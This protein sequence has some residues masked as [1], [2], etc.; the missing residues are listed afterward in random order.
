MLKEDNGYHNASAL[1]VARSDRKRDSLRALLKAIPQLRIIG[2]VDDASSALKLIADHQPA[3]TLLDFNLPDNEAW[4]V[5]KQIKTE[6][7]QCRCL[8]LIDTIQQRRMAEAAHAD[9]ML[10]NGFSIDEFFAISDRL[11]SR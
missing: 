3:L 10:A 11:L 7:P 8:V 2:Q 4:T 1:I 5:L 9:G 6:W